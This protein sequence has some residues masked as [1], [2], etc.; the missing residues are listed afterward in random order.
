LTSNHIDCPTLV[1]A[2]VRYG[3]DR[4]WEGPV[5]MGN[6]NSGFL[7]GVTDQE[8]ASYFVLAWHESP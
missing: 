2:V 6:T 5:V 4:G 8:V 3:L 1:A 7:M